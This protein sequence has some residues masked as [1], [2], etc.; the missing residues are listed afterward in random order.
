MPRKT[1]PSYCRQRERSRPDRA[2]VLLNGS[3]IFLGRYGSCESRRRYAGAISEWKAEGGRR[4]RTTAVTTITELLVAFMSHALLYYRRHDGT[5]TSEP[6]NYRQALRPLRELYGFTPAG[7]FGPKRLRAVRQKMIDAGWT[8][9]N[10][11]KQVSRIRAVFRWAVSQELLSSEI[12]HALTT[13]AP[14]KAGRTE[15]AES[16]PVRPVDEK[17]IEATLPHLS[18]QV[19]AMV[20]LQLVTGMRPGELITMRPRDIDRTTQPWQYRP[21]QHKTLHHGHERVIFL[22]RKAQAIITPY[23]L[24][25]DDKTLF[26]PA[27]AE[28]QRLEAAHQRRIESGTPRS[29]GNV[30]GSNRTQSPKRRPGEAWERTSYARCIARACDLAYPLPAEWRRQRVPARGHKRN[31]TRWETNAEIRNRLGPRAWAQRQKWQKQH[32]WNPHQLR[33]SAA[34]RLRSAYGLE[35]A[36]VI[37]GHATLAATQVY[38]EKSVELARKIVTDA[39]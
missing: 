32:C 17:V 23:L 18:D 16:D 13:L 33:H 9:R 4:F 10:I 22:G 2:Y 39:G 35:A 6:D 20:Q 8:R 5:L 38:A 7:E 26:S 37:L 11:N 1:V 30:P 29:C 19:Q 21:P 12:H 25:P 36:Q 28:K 15:A 24:R 34:T 3:R 14:L 27:E 31:A